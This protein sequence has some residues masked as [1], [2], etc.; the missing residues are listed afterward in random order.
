M[1]RVRQVALALGTFS[2]ALGVG[3][4]MQN[5]DALASRFGTD[6]PEP[7]EQETG[8]PSVQQASLAEPEQSESEPASLVDG[9]PVLDVIGAP[10]DTL[11]G[12]QLPQEARRPAPEPA[13][14]LLAA[15][16]SDAL[17]ETLN[18]L[19]QGTP[20]APSCEIDMQAADIGTSLVEVTLR[21]P[22]HGATPFTVH[23][24]GM[25]FTAVTSATGEAEFAVP[26]LGEV[27]IIVVAFP[28][29]AGQ[30]VTE[31]V[32]DFSDFDRA[33]LQWRGDV[34]VSLN[35]FEEGAGFGDDGHI[36]RE[37][38]GSL[39]DALAGT[40]GALVTLGDREIA[41]ALRAEVY[42]YP[43][44]AAQTSDKVLIM[45]EATI[46]AENCGQDIAA[47]SIQ[48]FPDGAAQA[49]DLLMTMPDCDGVGDFLVLHGMFDDL[50]LAAR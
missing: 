49:L 12:V 2:V 26:A 31:E 32:A 3:F 37:N 30:V 24:Q 21:A 8:R 4:V 50:V 43:S 9:G 28:D 34:A 22:C 1:S 5:G 38:T 11:V 48:V 47:Q 19:A 6:A 23:H 42:V 18:G 15:T 35:A 41:D 45:A 14:A 33:V 36:W 39:D 13:P 44:G 16:E 17:P 7:A 27:A 46:T 25:M 10:D 20:T 40:G 29:G